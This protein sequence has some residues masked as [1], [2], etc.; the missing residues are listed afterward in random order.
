MDL[1]R[2]D[3]LIFLFPDPTDPFSRIFDPGDVVGLAARI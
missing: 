1:I 2:E 3:V